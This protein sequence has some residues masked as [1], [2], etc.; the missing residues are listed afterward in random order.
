MFTTLLITLLVY[1]LLIVISSVPLW[2]ASK[3]LGVK[4]SSLLNA[5]IATVAGGIVTVVVYAFTLA[6][7]GSW[8][9][10]LIIGFIAYLWV[11]KNVYDVSWGKAALLYIVSVITV[12]V[13]A[14]IIAV[15]LGFLLIGLMSIPPHVFGHVP[16]KIKGI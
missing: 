1:F 13:L 9:L 7:T 11:I 14:V 12:I 8:F 3:I 4:K 15:V 16:F 10:S 5:I 2:L 6:I